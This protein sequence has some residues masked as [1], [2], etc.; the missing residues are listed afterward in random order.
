[1]S[2][3]VGCP[4]CHAPVTYKDITN[5]NKKGCGCALIVVAI[6][7]LAL[8]FIFPFNF[9]LSLCFFVP[10]MLVMMSAKKKMVPVCS[11]CG[12]KG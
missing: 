6:L 2:V 11:S 12:W 8:I 3:P 9:I 7:C 10:G 4:N 5:T 1:M